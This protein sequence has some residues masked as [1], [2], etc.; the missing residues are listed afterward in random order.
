MGYTVYTEKLTKTSLSPT[1]A[2]G[3]SGRIGLNAAICR[4]FKK[5]GIEAVLLL[6]DFEGRKIALRATTKNEKWSYPVHY[7]GNFSSGGVSAMGFLRSI[8]WDGEKYKKI[9]AHWDE[10]NS[11]L[12]FRLPEWG[13][14]ERR[15]L[16]PLPVKRQK[17][18]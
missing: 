6:S 16:L 1:V 11:S 18:G 10:A 8:G 5:N 15:K 14:N 9:D 13:R 12:E 17:A 3:R 4:I 2:I 7:H